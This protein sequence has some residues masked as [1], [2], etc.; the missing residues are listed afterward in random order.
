[1]LASEA[2]AA[3]TQT[4]VISGLGGI[5][6]TQTAL[7]YA[8][9][10]SKEYV[11]IFW[12]RAD[13]ALTIQTDFAQI[14]QKLNLV[15]QDD[16]QSA[17]IVSAVTR[18]LSNIKNPLLL[19][20]DNVETPELIINYRPDSPNVHI[21]ITSR[22]PTF[23]VLGIASPVEL[24]E[25]DPEEA[26]DF[27]IRRSGNDKQPLSSEAMLSAKQLTRELGYLPLALEQAGAYI[28]R[29]KTLFP[30]Y[31][32]SYLKH[33]IELLEREKP[34]VG[35][36]AKSVA[37]T[38]AINFAAVEQESP[39]AA[40]L[41]RCSA[42]F[43][44]DNIPFILITGAA[45][46]LGSHLSSALADADEDPVAFDEILFPLLQYSLIKRNQTY[47]AYSIHRLVQEVLKQDLA[48][49]NMIDTWFK[50]AV[51]AIAYT[52]PQPEYS[53]WSLC[54][55]LLPHALAC[56]ALVEEKGLFSAEIGRMYDHCGWYLVD[57]G[58]YSI[59][60]PLIIF[61][62]E[63]REKALGSEHL[64]VAMSLNNLASVFR[65]SGRYKDVLQL[66]QQALAM[67][68]KLI[69]GDHP[70]IATSLNNLGKISHEL[71]NYDSALALYTEALAMQTRIFGNEHPDIARSLGNLAS[72]H[73]T[74]RNHIEA[75]K[76]NKQALEM[77]KK[78]LEAEHPD[79]AA[80]L[81]NLAS[82]Y[83]AL[84]RYDEAEPLYTQSI[85]MQRK[86]L[87]DEHPDLAI[88]LNNHARIYEETGQYHK[89]EQLLNEALTMQRKLLGNE[90]P[91]IASS[92]NN[93]ALIQVKFERFTD[94]RQL[95]EQ[96]LVM[97]SNLLGA[98]HPEVATILGNLGALDLKFL[99]YDTAERFL[100]R[101]IRICEKSFGPNYPY[102]VT[103]LKN[104]ALVLHETARGKQLRQTE[105]R[106]LDKRAAEVEAWNKKL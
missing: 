71:G 67:R 30:D 100:R 72:V 101:A 37:T 4:Q 57:Q 31:L 90:H 64:D 16:A 26:Y 42:F 104:L 65:A 13:S 29:R 74:I 92:L 97:R 8:Y 82:V 5:G 36:K 39:A 106:K 45:T 52:F 24:G 22:S 103:L 46:K 7:E 99:R 33:R 69:D 11:C 91:D 59:A 93:I 70:D 54:R 17:V 9:R 47:K 98:E 73:H 35:D 19:V 40:D 80:N 20:F 89:A 18:Y 55:Y 14:A 50:R 61:G 62:K 84:G 2:K 32:T 68:K 94:A 6:K 51:S 76:L 88:S 44:A 77:R 96:A 43:G 28:L 23:D 63:I 12:I 95:F 15:E 25:M 10:Y 87:G 102:L 75:E 60:E 58:Q 81:N 53:N 78:L 34:V 1:M 66:F 56:Q 83:R 41:L 3:L 38:W 21:L 49:T 85:A 48:S 86:L 79:I 105:A 27:L